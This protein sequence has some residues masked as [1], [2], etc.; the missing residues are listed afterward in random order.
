M[1]GVRIV[2]VGY[3]EGVGMGRWQA[4]GGGAGGGPPCLSRTR[5]LLCP[6][7]VIYRHTGSKKDTK[8]VVTLLRSCPMALPVPL[9]AMHEAMPVPVTSDAFVVRHANSQTLVYTPRKARPPLMAGRGNA[10]VGSAAQ[11]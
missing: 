2:A 8:D 9:R 1:C 10:A 7:Y 3:R 4:C 6:T 11:L 5:L